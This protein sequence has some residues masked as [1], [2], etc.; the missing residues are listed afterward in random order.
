MLFKTDKG[1][2][3]TARSRYLGT[4]TESCGDVDLYVAHPKRKTVYFIVLT[5]NGKAEGSEVSG[6]TQN[7]GSFTAK[8]LSH[9]EAK[10]CAKKCPKS[11]LAYQTFFGTEAELLV[12]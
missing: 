12:G 10:K 7:V 11:S 6:D 3:S 5:T 1:T 9:T 4:L 2:L 8:I